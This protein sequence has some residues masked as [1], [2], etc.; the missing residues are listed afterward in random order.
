L[1]HGVAVAPPSADV[2]PRAAVDIAGSTTLRAAA[3]KTGYDA[4]D[5]DTHT[6]LFL[7]DVLEQ[8][9]SFGKD[10]SGL[11]PFTPWGHSGK[12]GDWE[13]DPEIVNHANPLD[14]LSTDDLRSVPT[15][16]LTLPWEDMFVSGTGIYISGSGV[17][18]A[19]SVEQILGDGRTGFQINGSVQIQGGSSTGRW[20]AD[21]LSMRLK[22]TS[23]FGPTRLESNLF[24]PDA[25][26]QLDT[27][28]LDAVLNFG[29]HH[30]GTDQ[31]GNAKF[32]QD[33]FVAN[34]QNKLGGV[35]PHARYHHL[36]INGLYWGM[37][38]VHERADASFAAKYL[39]G[40]KEDYDVIKHNSSTAVDGTT[41]KYRSMLTLARADLAVDANY[42]ALTGVLDI[43][44]FIDYMLLNFYAGNTDWAHQN[45]YASYN[46]V[47]PAGRWRFHSWD[48][49]HVLKSATENVTD[50]DD[51]GGPTEIHRNLL[52]NAEYRARFADHVEEHL[53]ND[54]VLTPE[55]AAAEYQKLMTEI[56]R[57]IVGE[58]AR[59]GDN[60]VSSPYRRTH[61]LNTQNNLL[62]N[63]FPVRTGNVLSQL[64]ADGLYPS[65]TV[66]TPQFRI[67]GTPL[68]GG[69]TRAGDSLSMS[70]TGG[71]IYYTT[72]GSDP[73]LPGGAIS[74]SAVAYV[75]PLTLSNPLSVQARLRT[76]GGQ[77]SAVGRAQFYV[78]AAADASNLVVSEINYNPHASLPQFG[79][80]A[81]DSDEFEFVELQNIG[82]QTIE[83]ANVQFAQ[84][85]DGKNVQGI[86]L[87]FSQA[88]LA[89]G[90]RIVAV[91]NS[92][93]F[94]SRYGNGARVA[95]QFT[96]Q[97]NDGGD[98]I[99]LLDHSGAIIQQF[100][101]QDSGN[102]P[103]RADGVGSSLELAEPMTDP[104]LAGSWQSSRRFGGTPG[105]AA[106]NTLPDVVINEILTHTDPPVVD[107]IELHNA[108]SL[109]V[110]VANWYVSD[111]R[112]QLLAYKISGADTVIP[113]GG[114]LVLDENRLGFGFKGQ[115]NDDAWLVAADATGK[116]LRFADHVQFGAAPSEVSLG[117]WPDESGQLFPMLS[118]TLGAANSGPRPPIVL[119]SEL[120]YHP[121]P[122]PAG[123]QIAQEMLEF[124][125][126]TNTSG[127]PLDVS[128]WRLNRAIDF[129]FPAGT[130]MAAGQSIVVVPFNPQSD[131]QTAGAFRTVHSV[132]TQ[133]LL[134]GPY[135]GV[136]DNGGESLELERPEDVGQLG[137]GY[138]LVDRAGYDDQAPWPI[139]AD[140]QGDS[141]QRAAVA[142]YGD[143]SG[144]WRAAAPTAGR[145]DFNAIAGDLNSDRIVDAKDIDLLCA[146]I[147]TGS[148][149]R[150]L[151]GDGL[152]SSADLDWMIH[153]ILRTSTGDA[154]LDGLFDSSDL[155]QIFQIGEYEDA[156]SGNSSWA[157]GDWNCDGEFDS[158]DLVAAFQEGSYV[159]NA[160]R[161]RSRAAAAE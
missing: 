56:D 48:A 137:V 35:A 90:E 64:R 84:T 1:T 54:G 85:T 88:A 91:A 153:A 114:Y 71:T 140:G 108:T 75:N 111:N 117:R 124:V 31:T 113:P 67:N 76:A 152:T 19:V 120:H 59:W 141:L 25:T 45:W 78:H 3:F 147:Q 149:A 47:D 133:T 143:L 39:G 104:S 32:I 23:Q 97:L 4:T 116:P 101:F 110:D 43:D 142:S 122:P 148:P 118:P 62:N 157:E 83:L 159:T 136:L 18:R 15:L 6:Y 123:A 16:S 55:N 53:F 7:A 139:S 42:Q 89:P 28:V 10:G 94:A 135:E 26:D 95:G 77:W 37:Y 80:M 145:T 22:F 66:G 128:Y 156:T 46:R 112:D 129:Q 102:W 96:G 109:P 121:A 144:S 99:T 49:E 82:D 44:D 105:S 146:S 33:Q 8:N 131:L 151:N 125:E 158:S 154:N 20:K 51:S 52:A 9:A 155:V 57:A 50:K 58:S 27:I 2:A 132:L 30:P 81:V 70:A 41:A 74:P 69:Y 21:K 63:Y 93:A 38:Y 130:V 40:E 103:G 29:F 100:S 134:L 60:R 34:L 12:N 150:D 138:I 119:V 161:L 98:R 86:A 5:V 61:W 17:P 11:P 73:R 36:Y 14:R 126:L 115:Q 92:T 65:S 24:G 87:R 68:Q 72:D 106:G 79:E 13:V 127:G 160:T 107:A